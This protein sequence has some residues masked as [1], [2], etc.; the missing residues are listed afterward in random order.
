MRGIYLH[1]IYFF[2]Y[3]FEH[4][5]HIL[6]VRCRTEYICI[7]FHWHLYPVAHSKNIRDYFLQPNLKSNLPDLLIT[8]FETEAPPASWFLHF[9][10]WTLTD[11]S[12]T[13]NVH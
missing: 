9:F 10:F 13:N 3:G 7:S 8:D 11:F 12:S 4:A 2:W 5:A 6:S 1:F